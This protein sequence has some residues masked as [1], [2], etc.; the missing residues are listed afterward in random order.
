MAVRPP[1]ESCPQCE[2]KDRGKGGKKG[3]PDSDP[4]AA[5]ALDTTVLIC[6]VHP[7]RSIPW[8][9]DSREGEFLGRRGNEPWRVESG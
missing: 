2:C 1:W 5:G 4:L 6:K 3:K 8:G 7:E 9:T